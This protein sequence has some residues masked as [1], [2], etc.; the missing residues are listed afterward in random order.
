[1]SEEMPRIYGLR[2]TPRAAADIDAAH[3]RFMELS[4][5]ELADEWKAGLFDAV[6]PL[7]TMPHRQIAPENARFQQ[8]VRQLIYRRR[9]GSVAYRILFTIMESQEDAPYVRILHVRHGSARPMTR[10]EA[11][12]I[13]AGGN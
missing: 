5:E 9:M 13:E 4:S 8:E 2:F 6:A 11:R 3:A 1:M 10:A 12:D 7:S